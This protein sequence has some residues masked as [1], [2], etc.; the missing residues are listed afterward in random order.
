MTNTVDVEPDKKFGR[1]TAGSQTNKYSARELPGATWHSLPEL[2]H[3]T[4]DMFRT[5]IQRVAVSRCSLKHQ[6][7]HSD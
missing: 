4:T 2:H 7:G 5:D 6:V 3:H 1:R